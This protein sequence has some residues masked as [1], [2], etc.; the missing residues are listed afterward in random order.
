MSEIIAQEIIA[1][2][3]DGGRLEPDEIQDFLAG[4]TDRSVT[5][6]Q[7]AAMLMAIY[8]R[9]LDNDE[10]A[11]WADAMLHS[12]EVIDLSGIERPCVDKHSTGGVGDKISIPLAP[13]VAACGAAVP[14][15]SGRGLG[16]TGGTLDKLESIPGFTTGLSKEEFVAMVAELGVSLIGQTAEIAPADGILYALRDATGT[17]PSIPLIASSIMSKKL[18]EG[19]DALVLDCKVGSGAFMKT[20]EDATALSQAIIAIGRAGGKKVTAMLTQ[21]EAPIGVMVGNALE[22]QESIDVLKGSGPRDTR[23]LTVALGGEMLMLA[24]IAPDTDSAREAIRQSLDDGT[25]IA[26]FGQI[27]ERQAGD[28]AVCDHPK[29]VLPQAKHRVPVKSRDAGTISDIDSAAI[30]IAALHLG[31]GRRRKEDDVDPAVGIEVVATIGDAVDKGDPLVYLHHNDRGVEDAT[32][33]VE[34]AYKMASETTSTD[35]V[36]KVIR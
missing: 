1:K 14:M 7:A 10:L 11:V 8:I 27:V 12:G 18:A 34:A 22:I 24:G 3:R 20:V 31:G 25:A 17:V 36:I 23:R 30:G 21:M 5:D 13:A 6:Y 19:I 28:P 29:S 26:K 9:G 15:I 35:R 16:H 32:R 33:T 2:K 4:V